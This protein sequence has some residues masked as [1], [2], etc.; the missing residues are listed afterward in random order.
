MIRKATY[1]RLLSLLLAMLAAGTP[2]ARADDKSLIPNGAFALDADSDAWPDGW[3]RL[4][5]GG[6]WQNEEGKHFLRLQSSTEGE[7]V[8]LYRPIPIPSDVRALEL[9]FSGRC[10]NLVPGKQPWFDARILMDFKDVAGNKLPAKIAVPFFRKNTDGWVQ[11]TVKFLVPDGAA[12]LDFM[13]SLFQVT[14]GTFDLTDIE[15]RSVNPGPIQQAETAA[16]AASQQKAADV[17]AVRRK[18]AAALLQKE[19][20]LIPNATFEADSNADAWPDTWGK[21]K[22][23]SWVEE[24][25]NHFLRMQNQEPGKT[26][27]IHRAV[28]I[29]EGVKALDLSWRWRVTNLK[30]GKEP[31]F[32]ARFMLQ[33]RDAE[34]KIMPSK[35]PPP[36]T[37]GNTKGWQDRS[38]KF[39]VP[40]EALTVEVMPS[41]FQVNGGTMD[42]D[43]LVIRPVDPEIVIAEQKA[44][45]KANWRP[46]DP[47]PEAPKPEK[48]PK[49]IRVAGNRLHD[50]SGK[51]VWLQGIHVV[52]LEWNPKGESVLACV[53]A[54]IDQWKANV[55]RLSIMDEYWMAEKGG[56]EYQDLVDAAVN[57]AANRGA[58]IVLD[59]HR[60]RA[61]R[62]EHLPF[63]KE[64]ATKYK[65]HPAV[66]FDIINEPHTI[67][68]KVWRDGGFVEEKKKGVDESAFLSEEEKKKN[69]QGFESPGMQKLVEA[70]RETG[71]K[72]IIIAGGLDWAYDLSGIMEG[73]ELEDKTGNGIMYA[74]HIYPWK[75]DWQGKVLRAAAKHP[76]F[77][78]EVGADIKKMDFLPLERQEDPYTWVPD[79]LGLIQQ[80]R[81]NW[82]AFSFHTGATPVMLA[83]W[84]F[85]PTPFWGAPAKRALAG[86]QFE[87]KKLR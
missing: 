84:N 21:L 60:Y 28:D 40:E 26:V 24:E 70:I 30:P 77:V 2:P 4:T 41:L 66:L 35:V 33:F 10:T 18:N 42:L 81:L 44:R 27:M 58:Y 80:Y 82:T 86:E 39:M 67:S 53:V 15:L 72:N 62:A 16:K 63:W 50:P 23:G 69:H 73:Y 5:S 76:I 74:A 71:A 12:T 25:G 79:M 57:L 85:T 64:V 9:T 22:E 19:G 46:A 68:W 32:D 31:W 8:M 56:K 48:W 55:I 34:G 14:S 45:E 49:E 38:A 83:D 52:S 75:S 11:K 20:S 13:P 6:S 59:N 29:P 7:T 54:A 37:R 61:V 17:A 36:Y 78:G 87:L 47:A 1:S 51:E 43:N 65:N 3:P